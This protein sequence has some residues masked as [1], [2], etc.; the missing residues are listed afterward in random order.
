MKIVFQHSGV[1]PVKKYGGIERILFWHMVELA[2]R[3][4]QV[5]LFGHQDS[6]VQKFGIELKKMPESLE[7]FEEQIPK[8]TDLIHLTYN[9]TPK[10]R[11][12]P[13]LINIQGNGQIGERFSLN[14]V[15][16]SRK[17]AENHGSDVFVYNAVDLNEYPFED[18]E[19]SLGNLL[20]LA[21]GSWS[22]KNL[23]HCIWLAKKSKL[24]LHIAGGR[25]WIPSRFVKPYGMVGGEHK[26]QLLQDTDALL[27]P[28]RWH[29]P[30][31]I[32]IIEAMACG[33]PVFGSCYGS[34]PE[35][36]K[37]FCGKTFSNKEDML[38]H[39]QSE[40]R[41]NR[42]EIRDYIEKNFSISRLTDDYVRLYEKILAGETLNKKEPTWQLEKPP[43]ELLYF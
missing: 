42:R 7:R 27:F 19:F 9:F 43:L 37:E 18:R 25:N 33:S 41:Y 35:L 12:I 20:F 5:V 13:C 1:L 29:E 21:K 28:V 14:T 30:F 24:K 34:L 2:K 17:H 3:G 8:D 39:L 40:P 15:F 10:K 4:H 11:D 36:I 26:L 38:A 31:G 22:V 6:Q 32:A 16:V 23:K